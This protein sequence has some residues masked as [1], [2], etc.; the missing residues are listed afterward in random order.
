VEKLFPQ[1][2][3]RPEH[4]AACDDTE[5]RGVATGGNP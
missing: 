4:R 1:P 5:S 3:K 2:V